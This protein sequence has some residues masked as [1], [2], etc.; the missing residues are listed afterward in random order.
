MRFVSALGTIL[1]RGNRA[2]VLPVAS[3]NHRYLL[4]SLMIT[5]E[6]CGGDR[7]FERY[8]WS[9]FPV[10]KRR[11]IKLCNHPLM[12][13][14]K[15]RIR[16]SYIELDIEELDI[17]SIAD[18]ARIFGLYPSSPL[19][20]R[21]A[22]LSK[23]YVFPSNPY[24]TGYLVGPYGDVE[25]SES[26]PVKYRISGSSM[27]DLDDEL[28]EWS[29][30][31]LCFRSKYPPESHQAYLDFFLLGYARRDPPLAMVS[32]VHAFLPQAIFLT[33]EIAG[34]SCATHSCRCSCSSPFGR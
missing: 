1:R 27:L 31:D 10:T 9:K 15:L 26:G 12:F 13:K 29:L 7:Y 33:I 28:I 32:D 14:D 5:L 2:Q 3:F 18:V 11:K 17:P 24:V 8:V 6:F 21:I 20:N 23:T 22:D 19:C 16:K 34:K 30:G 4:T 25:I